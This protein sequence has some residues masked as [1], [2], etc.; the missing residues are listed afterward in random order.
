MIDYQC[1]YFLFVNALVRKEG[2]QI[3][4]NRPETEF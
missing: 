2:E 3:C 1:R 4:F